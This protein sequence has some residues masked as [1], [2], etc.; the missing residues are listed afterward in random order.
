MRRSFTLFS[1]VVHSIVI[2]AALYAQILADSAP[3]PL[4]YKPSGDDGDRQLR[5][6]GVTSIA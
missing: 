4:P 2:A 6:A 1:I 5:A 3:L